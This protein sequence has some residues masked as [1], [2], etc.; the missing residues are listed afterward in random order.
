MSLSW[1]PNTSQGRMFGDYISTSVRPGGLAFPMIPVANQP[2]AGLFD[3]AMYAPNPGLQIS[4][5]LHAAG[6]GL[7][8]AVPGAATVPPGA[9]ARTAN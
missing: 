9:P 5:G 2:S 1:L 6:R 8:A 4:G 7:P 3:Q